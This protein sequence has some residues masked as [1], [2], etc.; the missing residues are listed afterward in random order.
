MGEVGGRL[1]APVHE[2]ELGRKLREKLV[3]EERDSGQIWL[4]GVELGKGEEL[5]EYAVLVTTL[6][7]KD[8]LTLSQRHCDEAEAE[9]V[10]DE[11][12]NQWGW[13][14]FTTRDLKRSQLMV[15]IF[16]W[17]SLYS[18]LA[19]PDKHAEATTSHPLFLHG[20]ARKTEHGAQTKLTMTSN[21]GNAR[22]VMPTLFGISNLLKEFRKSAEPFAQ[23]A[24]WCLLLRLIFKKFYDRIGPKVLMPSLA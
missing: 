8:L 23:D 20:V 9:N 14:G 6:P 7:S 16:N 11:L 21:H 22:A 17:W 18:R 10:F 24:R 13:R 15:L 2:P 5:F 1:T 19:L 12:K 4:S 3:A